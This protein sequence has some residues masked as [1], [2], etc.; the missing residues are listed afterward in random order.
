[1]GISVISRTD[2]E[3]PRYKMNYKMSFCSLIFGTE[4]EKSGNILTFGIKFEIFLK[5]VN[6]FFDGMEARFFIVFSQH[7]QISY[8]K[9]NKM[10]PKRTPQLLNKKKSNFTLHFHFT[11]KYVNLNDQIP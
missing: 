4:K 3:N 8:S 2:V 10:A 1:M 11:F 6:K 9:K 5:N 7:Y